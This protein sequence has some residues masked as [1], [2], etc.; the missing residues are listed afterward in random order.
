MKAV[1]VIFGNI[2]TAMVSDP[3]DQV[4][5]IISIDRQIYL[6]ESQLVDI[7]STARKC[8][9]GAYFIPSMRK[10]TVVNESG[11]ELLPEWQEVDFDVVCEHLPN[12]ERRDDVL[13]SDILTRYVD[14]E[15]DDGDEGR[16]KDL[17]WVEKDCPHFLTKMEWAQS[18]SIEWDLSL[19]LEAVKA[20]D[21]PDN[22]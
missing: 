17:D 13:E 21:S 11:V 22:N 7:L 8:N 14:E 3:N 5:R 19:Y 10:G 4:N 15:L 18:C 20:R 12:Y 2:G 6:L 1:L 16:Q 9:A